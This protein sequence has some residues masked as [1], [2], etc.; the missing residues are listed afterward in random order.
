MNRFCGS[1][2]LNLS[3]LT[4]KSPHAAAMI[5]GGEKYP[6]INGIVRFYKTGYGAVVVSEIEGLP[7]LEGKCNNSVFAF[8]IHEGSECS[9]NNDDPFANSLTHYNP[10]GCVHPFHAG[11]MPPL[12]GNRGY[13]LSV[14]LTDRFSVREIIGKT[15]IIHSGTDDF[16]SQPS[17]NAGEKIACGII[18][19]CI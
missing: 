19:S 7:Y 10:K 17:G 8:H 15:V 9:G 11:D 16:T 13:A 3:F 18:K 1:G 12:F 6:E 4:E 2:F 14:F 5:K